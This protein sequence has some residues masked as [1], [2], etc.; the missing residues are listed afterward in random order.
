M[1]ER[2]ESIFVQSDLDQTLGL[3]LSPSPPAL[4]HRP[5]SL[6]RSHYRTFSTLQTYSPYVEISSKSPCRLKQRASV[7]GL[8][9]LYDMGLQFASKSK[10]EQS[11]TLATLSPASDLPSPLHPL[12]RSR[13]KRS[14][15][16]IF[17]SSDDS[18]I[19]PVATPTLSTTAQVQ[20]SN[21]KPEATV[22]RTHVSFEDPELA[23][24]F[25]PKN[26]WVER[27]N[28]KLH[29]YYKEVPYMQAYDP[30][31]LE[32]YVHIFVFFHYLTIISLQRSVHGSFAATTEQRLSYV[33]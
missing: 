20:I 11:V 18:D 24:R 9:H 27:N 28:M 30:I 1:A 31:L 33:S 32:R 17:I 16:S 13:K 7:G 3:L 2:P 29:P 21:E 12:N 23:D 14:I 26:S 22:S 25:E 6:R 5:L 8:Q 4:T 19:T 15:A 10:R